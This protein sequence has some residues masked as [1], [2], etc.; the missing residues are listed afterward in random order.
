MTSNFELVSRKE[1]FIINAISFNREVLNFTIPDKKLSA[2]YRWYYIPSTNQFVPSKYVKYKDMDYGKYVEYKASGSH[3]K[4]KDINEKFNGWFE[5]VSLNDDRFVGLYNGLIEM[6]NL[7][8]L[9]N[10][11]SKIDRFFV[12]LDG[13]LEFSCK[14]HFEFE[15]NYSYQKYRKNHRIFEISVKNNYNFMCAVTGIR[16]SELLIASHIIP[17]SEKKETRL[18]SDNGIC[19]SPLIDKCFDKGLLTFKDDYKLK[20]S[21]EV[22]SDSY[23]LSMLSQYDGNKLHLPEKDFPKKEYL[24]WHRKNI[25]LN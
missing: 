22:F 3:G 19:L 9:S 20:L 10:L 23:L 18:D 11:H 13:K 17:W 12:L 24:E 1:E 25:F 5:E 4:I 14:D 2:F 7:R 15:D 8:G 21:K 16:T 6:M